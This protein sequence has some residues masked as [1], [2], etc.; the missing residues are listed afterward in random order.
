M[1]IDNKA[2]E[3]FDK[4]LLRTPTTSIDYEVFLTDLVPFQ[5]EIVLNNK[6]TFDWVLHTFFCCLS[7]MN[8]QASFFGKTKKRANSYG[9]SYS[10]PHESKEMTFVEKNPA[11]HPGGAG[12]GAHEVII[13]DTKNEEEEEK[14]GQ[15]E[16]YYNVEFEEDEKQTLSHHVKKLTPNPTKDSVFKFTKV[17]MQKGNTFGPMDSNDF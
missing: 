2:I 5:N 14:K 10:T 3:K 1:R 9:K 12:A 13:E 4:T 17:P 15:E 7:H 8:K 6:A 11:R 16:D